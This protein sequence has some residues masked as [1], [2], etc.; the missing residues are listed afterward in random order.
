MTQVWTVA[1][2]AAGLESKFRDQVGEFGGGATCYF[3]VMRVSRWVQR[4]RRRKVFAVP[5]FPR[6]TFIQKFRGESLCDRILPHVF[7]RGASGA[8][9]EINP[10]EIEHL[11]RMEASGELDD[12]PPDPR[13][14]FQAGRIIVIQGGPFDGQEARVAQTIG[15]R[16]TT[17]LVD[18]FGRAVRIP[19]YQVAVSG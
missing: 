10:R 12:L 11:Q 3:P 6:Y 1:C 5:A 13:L 7:L 4:A 14:L 19:L 18:L 9:E 15:R 2:V 17:V 16:A 8:P